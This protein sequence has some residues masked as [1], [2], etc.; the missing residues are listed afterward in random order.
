MSKKIFTLL[1]LVLAFS[2]NISAQ[3]VED[4]ERNSL[5]KVGVGEFTYPKAK[6]QEEKLGKQIF[7]TV[8]QILLAG[9]TTTQQS[10]YYNAIRAC[11]ST[12][13]ANSRRVRVYDHVT[14]QDSVDYIVDGTINDITITNDLV[15][16]FKAVISVTINL[17][18]YKNRSIISGATFHECDSYGGWEPNAPEAMNTALQWLSSD[19]RDSFNH[20]FPLKANIVEGAS[21]K[22]DKQKEVY[23]DL[24]EK[25]WIKPGLKFSVFTL[26]TIAGK[27]ARRRIGEIEVTATMGP[28]I[29]LC[30]VTSGGKDIKTAIDNNIKLLIISMN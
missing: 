1:L 26:H 12:G 9:Q 16:S 10:G 25:F 4:D 19:I 5:I 17:R 2:L 3:D 18:S 11:V 28:D 24:G 30:K 13:L 15:G 6:E 23:I 7:G 21:D 29:S 20:V 27:E 22:K 8:S 14:P